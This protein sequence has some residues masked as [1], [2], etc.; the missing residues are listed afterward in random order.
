[1]K[2]Q[3]YSSGHSII[4]HRVIPSSVMR[5]FRSDV[6]RQKKAKKTLRRMKKEYRDE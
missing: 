3:D 4:V 1:M 6:A 2:A 5:R